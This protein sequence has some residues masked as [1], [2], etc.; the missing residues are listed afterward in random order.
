[1]NW[2]HKA[3][4]QKAIAALPLSNTLYYAT[5]RSMGSLRS[6]RVNPLQWFQAGRFMAEWIRAGG[7]EVEGMRFLEVGTGRNVNLPTALW[8]CGAAQVVTVDLNPYLLKALVFESNEYVRRHQ[9]A[10]MQLFG[11]EAERPLFQERLTQLVNFKGDLTALLELMN[12]KYLS[13]A[14][15][16]QL[17]LETQSIDVHVSLAVLEHIP[18]A[19]ISRILA[20]ARRILKAD[21]LLLHI[22][23]PSDHFSHDDPSITGDQLPAVRRKEWD[24]WAG[25]KFT[26]HNRLRAFEYL[27]LFEQ[28]GVR[29]LRQTESIDEPS[30][31]ALK[32]GFPLHRQFQGIAPEALAVRSLNVLG[33]FSAMAQ[34]SEER[35]KAKAV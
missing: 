17:P 19:I 32:N 29:M 16:S 27:E 28:A 10:V 3:R 18:A 34:Q 11:A 4:I 25:N 1:M 21:G 9:D 24:R 33:T 23:D 2:Q 13:H 15:A 8:L 30:L 7:R 35:D 12:I 14:D 20:E 22:I 26:Y 5:Q 6:G 31:H